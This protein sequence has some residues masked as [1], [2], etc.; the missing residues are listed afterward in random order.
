MSDEKTCECGSCKRTP[1]FDSLAAKA[2]ADEKEALDWLWS[3]ME[4]AETELAMENDR[5]QQA[6]AEK[7]QQLADANSRCE[8]LGAERDAMQRRAEA[9]EADWQACERENAKLKDLLREV[10][11][12]CEIARHY[13]AHSD[14]FGRIRD[15]IG[16]APQPA[17]ASKPALPPCVR[18]CE[19]CQGSDHHW[20]EECDE[21]GE[22][23]WVCKHCEATKPFDGYKDEDAPASGG[24]G[25]VQP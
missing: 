9:A 12:D 18:H 5:H 7:D 13:R 4:A 23:V 14:I 21:N 22:P 15:V 16:L 19:V 11:T 10:Y 17:P 1:Q 3:A 2:T 6:L 20:M 24:E 8:K 25:Q